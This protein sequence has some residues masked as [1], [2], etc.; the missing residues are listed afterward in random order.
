[1]KIVNGKSLACLSYVEKKKNTKKIR[2]QQWA[3][4]VNNHLS[5]FPGKIKGM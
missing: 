2:Q 4:N 3:K 1:M 5:D